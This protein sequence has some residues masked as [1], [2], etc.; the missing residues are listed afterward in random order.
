MT[1]GEM[2]K[3]RGEDELAARAAHLFAGV[4]REFLCA[5]NDMNTWSRPR[6][7]TK[8]AARMHLRDDRI[9]V[10]KL[11]T[12]AALA[13]EEQ[14]RHLLTVAAAG[15]QVRISAA[16]LPHETIII[17]R[18]VMILAGAESRGDREFTVTGSPALID[19]VYALFEAAWQAA[20][21]L[22]T[23][24][25]A[26]LPAI[27]PAARAVLQALG[28]GLTDEAAARRLG[29]SLRTYRRR[30]AELMKL[31]EAN[32][33]FQAGVQAGERGLAR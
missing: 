5:A 6:T 31:L 11:Y 13:D 3:V 28:D 4:R 24:L 1:A 32:S 19:G 23:L 8:I 16:A 12:A 9:A 33:R 29:M 15:A 7:R 18:R 25:R 22:R 2:M 14:R 17:D 20:V 21:G 10:R 26:D 30:V 27:D